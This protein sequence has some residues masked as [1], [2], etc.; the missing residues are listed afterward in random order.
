M[1]MRSSSRSGSTKT[2]GLPGFGTEVRTPTSS[3]C[4][5]LWGGLRE[6]RDSRSRSRVMRRL[7]SSSAFM[8]AKRWRFLRYF[9]HCL[10]ARAGASPFNFAKWAGTSSCTS[11]QET[12][13][14]QRWAT[15]ACLCHAREGGRR[16]DADPRGDV[17]HRERERAVG[18]PEVGRERAEHF[19]GATMRGAPG[20]R[21]RRRRAVRSCAIALRTRSCARG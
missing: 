3:S 13:A 9:F 6:T 21:K 14:H 5:R 1:S 16:R 12:R 18:D 10:T 11:P 17:T 19:H 15:A 4:T 7:K 8:Q 2:S 20:D